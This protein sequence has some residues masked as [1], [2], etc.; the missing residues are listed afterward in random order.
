MSLDYPEPSSPRRLLGTLFS[1]AALYTAGQLD[2]N[3]CIYFI[4][5]FSLHPYK[6][7][8][9]SQRATPGTFPWGPALSR[10]ILEGTRSSGHRT[11]PRWGR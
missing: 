9:G 2:A 11:L 5:P 6:W 7:L 8:P 3:F 1:G 10:A 4:K